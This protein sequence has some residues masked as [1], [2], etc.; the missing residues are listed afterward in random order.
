[1]NNGTSSRIKRPGLISLVFAVLC[2]A[3]LMAYLMIPQGA[4]EEYKYTVLK[5]FQFGFLPFFVLCIVFLY[6]R[7]RRAIKKIGIDWLWLFLGGVA[8]IWIP[9]ISPEAAFLDWRVGIGFSICWVLGMLGISLGLFLLAWRLS[10][11]WS[12]PL[13]LVASFALAFFIGEL[14]YLSTTQHTDGKWIDSKHSKYALSGLAQPHLPITKTPYGQLPKRPDNASGAAAHRELRY[15]R[16]IFDAMYTLNEKNRRITPRPSARP[17]A[18]LLLFGCSLT[19]GFGL[20]DEETWAWL[21]AKDLGPS[22]RVEN[23]AFN[24][25]GA[26][27]M[28]LYLERKMIDPPTAPIRQAIFLAIHDHIRRNSGLFNHESISYVLTD[29]GDVV[30]GQNT[31]DSPFQAFFKWPK[32]FNGSQLVREVSGKAQNWF[33]QRMEPEQTKT[34]VAMIE[35]SAKILRGQYGTQLNVLLWPGIE[36][37]AQDLKDRGIPVIFAKNFMKD[38]D[39]DGGLGYEIVPKVEPHPNARAARELADGLAAYFRNLAK[40]EEH[41]AHE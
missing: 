16:E 39:K 22:W 21:L 40:M 4:S 18:D 24:A 38:W 36:E 11:A 32:I 31:K 19:F 23:Y 5:I 3:V 33:V 13:C 26:Q 20:N 9:L 1:M 7:V 6:L 30:R 17:D 37:I 15:S 34:Y 35:K 28:L 10:N 41:G 8:I 27:Q 12:G 14:A 29:N 25:F 2:C